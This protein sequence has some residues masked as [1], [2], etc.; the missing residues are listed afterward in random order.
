[1]RN[2]RELLGTG[3][4]IGTALAAHRLARSNAPG[5]NDTI[6]LAGIGV[7]GRFRHLAKSFPKIPGLKLVAV[8]DVRQDNL[9]KGLAIAESNAFKTIEYREIL[10]RKDIDAVLIATPDH[11]HVPIAIAALD[12]GKHVYVEKPLTHDP[13]EGRAMLEAER[14]AKKAVQVG[15]QQRSM[16]HIQKG[17]EIVRSGRL[18]KIHKVHLTWNRNAPRGLG[19][20]ARF[21]E[22]KVD[23]KRFLGSA[24]SQPFDAFKMM[25]WRW[26][27]DF[28]GGIFTDLMV[29]FLDVVNWY[30]DL[31]LP[32]TALSIG[33]HFQTKGIWETPDTV[34][35]LMHYPD[36]QLQLYFEGTFVN[37]RNA[38]MAEFMG[39]EGTLYIDRG[40]YEFHPERGKGT[41]EE[42][43][44]GQG[45][46][47]GD[48]YE[49]PDGELLHLQNWVDAIR[50]G[51]P[52]RCPAG[53][54]VLA[55]AAAHMA[56]AS[57]RGRVA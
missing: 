10:D 34:Q 31:P 7:G 12:A 49:A 8:C 6:R 41:Y 29:H 40:R 33:D 21:D 28:G 13:S 57:L 24:K 27:W 45:K 1:M 15:M 17:F 16:P 4:A 14:R 43:V 3:L 19:R 25:E 38:A 50:T 32:K 42:L 22:S 39:T 44:L 9:E 2:R 30:L 47:G 52:T 11:W 23:W 36:R 56:N 46:R 5:P 55:A 51:S 20:N 54:G 37:A 53:T 35:T 18:G 48:F 26:H